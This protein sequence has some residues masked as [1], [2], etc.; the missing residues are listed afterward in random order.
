MTLTMRCRITGCDL[1][2]CGVCQ[3][4]GGER[5]AHHQ[6]TDA[7][8]EKPCFRRKVCE[9]CGKER[10]NP[11]HDWEPAGVSVTGEPELKCARCGL[12]I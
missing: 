8:R 5:Q 4:C 12:S 10:Q 3:R 9:R 7:E 11:D 2:G 6:W 1:D